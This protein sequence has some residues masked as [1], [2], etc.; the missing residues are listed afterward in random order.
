[1]EILM[2]TST[3]LLECEITRAQRLLDLPDVALL[4]RLNG[5]SKAV[6]DAFKGELFHIGPSDFPQL[7]VLFRI[8]GDDLI[9]YL[10]HLH[11][12]ICFSIYS[13]SLALR[14]VLYSCLVC[15][16]R[17]QSHGSV[18][19]RKNMFNKCQFFRVRFS[20]SAIH[21]ASESPF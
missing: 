10:Q 16:R 15:R 2:K 4:C 8:N 21:S 5:R 6:Q 7:L 1:M 14:A 13:L 9:C 11:K 17:S 18:A 20:F 3:H 19:C 12:K